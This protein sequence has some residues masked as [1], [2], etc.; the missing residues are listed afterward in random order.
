MRLHTTYML[1][2]ARALARAFRALALPLFLAGAASGLAQPADPADP[3]GGPLS[4]APCAGAPWLECAAL[5]VPLKYGAP[6]HTVEV[7]VA[8]AKALDP[9]RRIGVMFVHPGGHASGI[10]FLQVAPQI[11]SNFKRYQE[12]FDIVTIDPRGTGRSQALH[13]DFDLLPRPEGDDDA[14]LIA[15]FDDYS[16]RIA[17]QCLDE[18]PE[19]VLSISGQNFARDIDELRKALGERQ[20]SLVMASNSGPVAG[21]YA[22]LFPHRVRAMVLDSPVGPEH[23]EYWIERRTEQGGSYERTLQRLDQ[24]CA[25]SPNCP[26]VTFGLVN[27][28]DEVS[29]RLKA[30]PIPLPNGGEFTAQDFALTFFSLLP[31][32]SLWRDTATALA[33]ALGGD[34]SPFIGIHTSG[35]GDEDDGIV[36]RFCNDYGPRRTAADYL[37]ITEAA[38]TVHPRF[39]NREFL[40]FDAAMCAAWPPADPPV[41]RN[42]ARELKVPVLTFHSEFDSDAPFAWSHRLGQALGMERHIVRYQGGGHGVID[43]EQPCIRDTVEEYLFD[44]Q[45]PK[46]GLTCPAEVTP[47]AAAARSLAADRPMLPSEAPLLLPT[48][49]R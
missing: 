39:L 38:G 21:A 2:A 17:R 42:V 36:A 43:R 30:Q 48:R 5:P 10:D 23:R 35:G 8:R 46:E 41:I 7:A 34:L 6:S 49:R 47:P 40:M 45:L 11:F 3:Q 19:F 1:I 44:L 26:L 25:R 16:R 14:T 28:F 27:A 12:R 15:Y 9:S 13:C 32:E 29:K 20:L 33:M 22:S 4:F 18:D 31:R 37:P 24:I